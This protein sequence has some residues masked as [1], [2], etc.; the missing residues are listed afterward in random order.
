LESI[1][2]V[3]AVDRELSVGHLRVR[4]E[5]GFKVEGDGFEREGLGVWLAGAI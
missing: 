4:I 1:R 2:E 3:L 5:R